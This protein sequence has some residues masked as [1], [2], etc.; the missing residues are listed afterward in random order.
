MKKFLDSFPIFELIIIAMLAGLGIATKSIISPLIHMVSGP[1]Y[2]PGGALAGGFY[3]MWIIIG[4]GI[5]NRRGTATLIA[6]V[7]GIM[8]LVSGTIGSHGIMSLVTYTLPGLMVDIWYALLRK[9]GD[10]LMDCFSGCIVANM[11]GTFLSNLVFFQLP[12]L[13]LILSLSTSALSGS[14]GGIVSYNIVRKLK[15][16]KLV[17]TES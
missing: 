16:L 4:A 7:Q 14:L 17:K 12:L 15:E 13:F 10:G 2:I 8:V 6:L 1:L 3:M 5:T 9:D 11:T